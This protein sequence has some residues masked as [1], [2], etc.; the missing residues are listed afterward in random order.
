MFAC[1]LGKMIR[2]Q[3]TE[4]ERQRWEMR[5]QLISNYTQGEKGEKGP[6]MYLTITDMIRK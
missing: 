3:K 1:S 2:F 5:E 6:V 4:R